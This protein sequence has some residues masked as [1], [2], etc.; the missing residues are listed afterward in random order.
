MN[1]LCY[2]IRLSAV[3]PQLR[4]DGEEIRRRFTRCRR[5]FICDLPGRFKSFSR[6][7]WSTPASIRGVYPPPQQPWRYSPISHVSPFC[8]PLPPPTNNFCTLYTQFCAIY[9]CFGEFWKLSVRDNDPQKNKKIQMELVKHIACFISKCGIKQNRASAASE[10]FFE[11][12][13]GRL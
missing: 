4:T 7:P 2:C 1:A 5:C 3:Q 9:A 8:H 6:R 10:K 11:K 12:M 13:T